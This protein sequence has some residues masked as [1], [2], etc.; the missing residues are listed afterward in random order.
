MIALLS[1]ILKVNTGAA[2]FMAGSRTVR[3][4][5]LHDESDN[6]AADVIIAHLFTF[7]RRNSTSFFVFPSIASQNPN[8]L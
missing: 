5:N 4:D 6:T 8:V 7:L 1:L 3:Y 2:Y